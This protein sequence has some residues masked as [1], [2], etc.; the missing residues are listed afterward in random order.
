MDEKSDAKAEHRDYA[1]MLED[2]RWVLAVAIAI[3]AVNI[4]LRI[5]MLRF[6]GLFEPDGFF[7]YSAIRQAV[8]N[9]FTVS[10]YLS[11]SGFPWHNQIGETH[12]LIYLTVAPYYFLRFFGIGYYTI[13][14]L[15]PVLFG[16]AYAI[17]AYYLAKYLA[18]SRLLGLLA[19]LFV[20]ISSGNL[21]RTAALV[22]RGDSFVS[23]FLMLGLFFMIRTLRSKDKRSAYINTALSAFTL[24]LGM[25]V[26][27]GY[28][29]IIAIYMLALALL[30]AYGFIKADDELLKTVTLLT[31]GLFGTFILEGIWRL[32][33]IGSSAMV[34]FGAS[35][36]VFWIPV[37]IGCLLASYLLKNRQVIKL[38]ETAKGRMYIMLAAVIAVL[39][40]VATAGG[41]TVSG[42]LGMTN[43]GGS[44]GTTTQELQKPSYSFLFASFNFQMYFAPL[45]ALLFVF[46]AHLTHNKEHHII[47][48]VAIN[49]SREFLV[50]LPYLA[51]TA[52]LQSIAIRWNALLSIPLAIFAAYGAYALWALVRN[53]TIERKTY[54]VAAAV[55]L[56][57]MILYTMYAGIVPQF[58]EGGMALAVAIPMAALLAGVFAYD[59]YAVAKKHMKPAYICAALVGVLVLFNFYLTYG[60]AVTA[61]Q[62]DGI[63]PEFLSAMV[64]MRN[65]TPANATAWAVWPDG[66]VI[67]GWA[68][69]TSYMDSVGGE[70]GTRI[71]YSAKFLFN[72]SDDP[73][74]FYSIGKPQY[75]VA[76]SFWYQEL[77]GLAV[78]GNVSNASE[79]G[80]A[81]LSS[82][83]VTQ[84]A[85]ARFYSFA[86]DEYPYYRALMIIEQQKNGTNKF[87]AYLGTLGSNQYTEIKHVMF[88]NTSS[89]AYSLANTTATNATYNY[90]LLISYS[91]SV[92]SGGVILG[93]TLFN[94]NVFR[95]TF[96]CNYQTCPY[97]N[98]DIN[99]TAVYINSDTR[100]FKVDYK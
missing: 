21:A 7:Y 20:S 49:T 56:G 91:G 65:N 80:Y 74:Y 22:Y 63:N 67:E 64:W 70:N 37:F 89:Y 79:Y 53:R 24:S 14:R 42:A 58:K 72:T 34:L 26:W 77:G 47:K 66:S 92:I 69:R 13:M 86:S 90:T 44:I 27:N 50:L 62:A 25:V 51:V 57:A 23:L 68:N 88:Y 98:Q 73:Q 40:I 15:M 82:L 8:Q 6:Q 43:T 78:E 41:S 99:L 97:D 11:I 95:L 61:T 28:A 81:M 12:G 55:A 4:F 31:A 29:F 17:L 94:S 71:Y 32:I 100:I 5:P 18:N 54:I 2:K 59:I 83:N 39:I 36:L 52:Y 60:S 48:W 45:G 93:P 85:T 30:L 1:K 3:I 46:F 96:L 35:F 19:M 76:R 38:A 75:I 84:N 9:N 10:S 16:V 33:G 87:T